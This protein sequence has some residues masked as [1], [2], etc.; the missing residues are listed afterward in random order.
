MYPKKGDITILYH[1]FARTLPWKKI[2]MYILYFWSHNL[3]T[4]L[5]SNC[6]TWSIF[7]TWNCKKR[8]SITKGGTKNFWKFYFPDIL[9]KIELKS[10]RKTFL[11]KLYHIRRSYKLQHQ[12]KPLHSQSVRHALSLALTGEENAI[13]SPNI[14]QIA[15]KFYFYRRINML[16]E[17]V[18]HFTPNTFEVA[19]ICCNSLSFPL[20]YLC[21]ACLLLPP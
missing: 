16:C 21:R 4:I 12:I 6:N 5:K 9:V 15:I 17:C 19:A 7:K 1:I 20:K 10:Q 18:W 3:L 11:C 2:C 14:P 8:I 13:N